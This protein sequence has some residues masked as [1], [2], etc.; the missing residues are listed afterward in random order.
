LKIVE[1]IP[2]DMHIQNFPNVTKATMEQLKTQA[3]T[4]NYLL[5]DLL[6]NDADDLIEVAN[7]RTILFFNGE[8]SQKETCIYWGGFDLSEQYERLPK[9]E[10]IA[11]I[12]KYFFLGQVGRGIIPNELAKIPPT[13]PVKTTRNGRYEVIFE[14]DFGQDYTESIYW[15]AH[16]DPYWFTYNQWAAQGFEPGESYDVYLEIQKEGTVEFELMITFFQDETS[17]KNFRMTTTQSNVHFPKEFNKGFPQV[18]LYIKGQGKLVLEKI[19][20]RKSRNGFGTFL[21]GDERIELPNGEEIL[22]YY[23]PGKD[24]RRL[25]VSFSGYLNGI[26]KFE[27]MNL[28]KFEFPLLLF[29]DGRASGGVFQLGRNFNPEYEATIEDII[30][31]KLTDLGL[32]KSDLIINGYSMGTYPALYYGAKFAAKDILISKPLINIGTMTGNRAIFSNETNWFLTARYYLAGRILDKDTPKLNAHLWRRLVKSKLNQ[33]NFHF[34]TMNQDEYDGSSLP[35][36][37]ES[38]KEKQALIYRVENEGTHT[39]KIP[40]MITF[41]E[42]KLQLIKCSLEGGEVNV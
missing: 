27:F 21:P 13:L 24:K 33:T 28:S 41:I 35:M 38:L 7:P 23:I 22:S 12:E 26:P 40:E 17:F 11:F 32:Q 1:I 10:L 42:E 8:S 2:N 37:L 39:Q 5:V 6:Q 18:S 19:K 14:G 34:F 16:S 36:L 15:G 31:E 30:E 29:Q 25:L 20:F 3:V 9:E 4:Y